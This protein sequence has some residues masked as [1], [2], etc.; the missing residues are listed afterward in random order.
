MKRAN[1]AAALRV[2]IPYMVLAVLW[3]VLSDLAVQGIA[4]DARTADL[5][6]TV[7][8]LVFVIVTASL[9]YALVS[10]ELRRRGR[11]EE[12]LRTLNVDLER[13]VALRTREL[14]QRERL[15]RTLMNTAP[16]VIWVADRDGGMIRVNQSW[17]RMTGMSTKDTLGTAWKAA[18]HPADAPRVLRIWGESIAS[19]QPIEAECRFQ[20]ADGAWADVVIV[21]APVLD[22]AGSVLYWV[23]VTTDVT[24]YKAAAAALNEA[25]R[26]L[27]SFASSISHD[28]KAPIRA[29][30]G[31]SEILIRRHRA[32]MSPEVGHLVDN[33]AL[34][35][36]RMSEL[37][38]DLLRYARLGT[39]GVRMKQ[40][41]PLSAVRQALAQHAEELASA[42]VT[43]GL[44][45]AIPSV[46][47]DQTLLV[48][49]VGNLVQN[50]VKYRRLDAD[51]TIAIDWERRDE[52]LVISVRDNGIGVAERNHARIFDVFQ[53][54]HSEDT[55]PGTGIGL[56]M[57][58]RAMELMQ[59]HVTVESEEG[60]GSTFHLWLP[61]QSQ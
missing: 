25:N 3:I 11:L 44:P 10:R 48:Q 1:R 7:K 16:Q 28:L 37:V 47:A 52:H 61:V 13:R 32:G 12:Q 58:K 29:V 50:A 8:G 55:V 9:L 20:A 33:V 54:L 14:S 2:V 23:G 21:A 41:E 60:V 5:V 59:G 39:Q 46:R 24:R 26:D 15:E 6:Q 4:D 45:D 17:T 49:A 43:V 18:L 56:A 19:G 38:E 30:L 57:V 22:E 31:F 40:L 53:R 34:A 35:A 51:P 36:A 42:G 27:R